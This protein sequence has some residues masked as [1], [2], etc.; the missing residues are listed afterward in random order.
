MDNITKHFKIL[1]FCNN[2]DTVFPISTIFLNKLKTQNLLTIN[3]PQS[4]A[5]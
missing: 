1:I 4:T 3:K 2:E 5:C